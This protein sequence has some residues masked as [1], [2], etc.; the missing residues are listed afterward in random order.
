MENSLYLNVDINSV[1]TPF[2]QQ[3]V[4]NGDLKK[5]AFYPFVDQYL[6]G[7]LT[8]LL[9]NVFCQ[10]SATP[11]KV[12]TDAYAK[13]QQK[14][15]NGIPVAYDD[16]Q[17]NIFC[18]FTYAKVFHENNIDVYGIWFARCKE[19]GIHP[20]L[21]VR[22]NDSHCPDEKTCFLRSDFFYEA[23]QKGWNVG[24]AYEYHRYCWNY[25]VPEVREKM[26]AYIE[27]QLNRYDV[28]GIELD[29]MREMI[30]FD[31]LHEKNCVQIMNDFMRNVRKIVNRAGEKW[32]HP[33]K[34]LAR[35]MRDMEQNKVYGFDGITWAKEG[36]IDILSVSARW[37]SCDS[38]LP[39]AEWKRKLPK[40]VPLVAGIETLMLHPGGISHADGETAK[41]YAA[42][43]FSEGADGFYLNNFFSNPFKPIP[44][45]KEVVSF[46]GNF[47]TAMLPPR[48]HVVTYQDLAPMGCTAWN[49]L[50]ST[51]TGQQEFSVL[52]GCVP[53]GAKATLILGIDPK[54]SD[55]ENAEVFVNGFP[56]K[57]F[58]PVTTYGHSEVTYKL[59]ENGYLEKDVETYGAKIPCKLP[60]NRQNVTII[61]DKPFTLRYLEIRI[62]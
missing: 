12:F 9:L 34:I 40:N 47:E 17:S 21:S 6:G 2:L 37:R 7:Q 36:L 43:F 39:V 35:L 4:A 55:L 56:C 46:C 10:Y 51:F 62:D 54:Q 28:Y 23:I 5:E 18:N 42:A 22:M 13:S 3:V 25:A 60:M 32:G 29:F 44:R 24:E 15:E 61:S 27:E 38:D 1:T 52:T 30:C 48:R 50:G 19:I 11:S 58:T 49:P 41:G 31:Y 8:D 53:E 26:L 45:T 16:T 33:V 14:E 57:D 20:W 59:V